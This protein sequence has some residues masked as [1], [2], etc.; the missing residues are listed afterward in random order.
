MID[1]HSQAGTGESPEVSLDFLVQ[2]GSFS[3]LWVDKNGTE[4]SSRRPADGHKLRTY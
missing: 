4:L 1:D 2:A 3:L